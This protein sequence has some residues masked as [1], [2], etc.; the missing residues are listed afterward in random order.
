[1]KNTTRSNIYMPIAAMILT[2]ALA[3]PTAAQNQAPF[4]GALKGTDQDIA[5]TDTTVTVLTTGKAMGSLG[6]FSF[7][8]E[9]TVNF[10]TGADTGSATFT[11]G[12]DSL[13]TT[14]VGSGEFAGK[15]ELIRITEIHTITG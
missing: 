10:N 11:S 5:F 4:N 14:V 3:V 2:A 13:F 15:A 7:T 1:M 8:Q 12:G 9:V 6:E